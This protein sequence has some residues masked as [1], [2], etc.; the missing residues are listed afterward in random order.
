MGSEGQPGE[1]YSRNRGGR[2]GPALSS[3]PP[4]RTP[5]PA[6]LQGWLTLRPPGQGRVPAKPPR[7]H[8]PQCL[9]LGPNF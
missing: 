2:M 3:P 5:P 6:P 8:Q 9:S 7:R 1:N 4:T